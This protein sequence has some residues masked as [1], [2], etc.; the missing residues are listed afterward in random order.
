MRS[1][2]LTLVNPSPIGVVTGPFSA[3]LLRRIESISSSGQRRAAALEREHAGQVVIPL[4]RDAGGFRM[5]TTASVTSG[6][7]PSPGM[8]VMV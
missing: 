4:D 2:T 1:P 8:S 3:T 5:R 7:M 6:P